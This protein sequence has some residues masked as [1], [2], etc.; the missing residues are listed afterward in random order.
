MSPVLITHIVAGSLAIVSGAIALWVRKGERAH[1]ASGTVFF[2][3]MLILSALGAY[4]AIFVPSRLSVVSGILT[5][6]LVATAWM[7]VRR[8]WE[9]VGAFEYGALLVALGCAAADAI[10]GLQAA[11]SP[12]GQ[13]EGYPAMAYYIFAAVAALA[14]GLDLKVIS[15]GGI[16]G[17]PRVARHLWRMCLAL[18]V[19]AGSFFLGQQKVMPVMIQGSPLL[20]LPVIAPLALM[21]F[22]MVRVRF[23]NWYGRNS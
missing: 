12:Q 13:L 2:F 19:A 15:R 11:A 16:S 8:K 3:S 20:F 18:F 22:W 6:Y 21:A 14:A 7:T 10:F 17:A 5:F 9:G 1:R 4:L 23:T